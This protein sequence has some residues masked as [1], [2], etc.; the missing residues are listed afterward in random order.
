MHN[1]QWCDASASRSSPSGGAREDHRLR[2]FR[3]RQRFAGRGHR[4]HRRRDARHHG[5]F[6]AGGGE[7]A[8]HLD[9]RAVEA[10]VARLQADDRFV[11]AGLVEQPVN[12]LFERHVLRIADFAAVGRVQR[13]CLVDERAGV[14]DRARL[15]EQLA[16][17]DGDQVGVAGA[18]ADKP[19]FSWHQWVLRGWMEKGAIVAF[20]ARS[21]LDV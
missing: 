11:A 9:Q 20:I 5:P 8:R 3:Q 4:R 7:R 2:D 15:F 10:G 14:E 13:R 21:F 19:D 18:G 16:A 1:V 17:L 12:H 6:D